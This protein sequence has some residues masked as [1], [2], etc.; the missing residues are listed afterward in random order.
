[1]IIWSKLKVW[2]S[3]TM[4]I[5]LEDLLVILN[6]MVIVKRTVKPLS[7]NIYALC[8]LIKNNDFYHVGIPE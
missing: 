7:L 6:N 1:M 2:Y 5:N 3:I 4:C 8:T